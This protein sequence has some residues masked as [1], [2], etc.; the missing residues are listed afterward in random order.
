M[1]RRIQGINPGGGISRFSKALVTQHELEA[2]GYSFAQGTEA[3]C[4]NRFGHSYAEQQWAV[5]PL[6]HPQYLH[7]AYKI[8]ALDEPLGQLGGEDHAP[9]QCRDQ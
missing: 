7:H 4:F 9:W 3:D 6:R 1:S 2:E 8:R 5:V